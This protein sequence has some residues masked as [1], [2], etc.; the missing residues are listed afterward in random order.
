MKVHVSVDTEE[1][2][3]R[4]VDPND[5][6]DAGEQGLYVT[7]ASV[8]RTDKDYGWDLPDDTR[9]CVVLV[10][11]YRD[12]CTFGSSEYAEVKGVFLTKTEAEEFARV[13][14]TDHGYFGTHIE[15]LN[16]VCDLS[17]G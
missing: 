13:Q 10:E 16:F 11:H 7:G 15:W 6:W 3:V 17:E 12:G 1:Y 5:S 14:N 2:V 9:F 4:E 8:Q